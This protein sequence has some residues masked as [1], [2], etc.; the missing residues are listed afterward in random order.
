M[1]SRSS[2]ARTH[3]MTAGLPAGVCCHTCIE[4]CGRPIAPTYGRR[5]DGTIDTGGVEAPGS[6]GI[7]GAPGEPGIA[8]ALTHDLP[9]CH[10]HEQPGSLTHELHQQHHAFC[11]ALQEV[12]TSL[13]TDI[14]TAGIGHQIQRTHDAVSVLEDELHQLIAR[15][16]PL[17][18][19]RVGVPSA[20][21]GEHDGFSPMSSQLLDA[22]QRIDALTSMVSTLRASLAL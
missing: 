14:R 6:V 9:G 16:E 20:P 21:A 13:A 19:C 5:L 17:L 10:A 11:G 18:S 7:K 3:S 4:A 15:L 2:T 8:D 12:K 22:N 1:C